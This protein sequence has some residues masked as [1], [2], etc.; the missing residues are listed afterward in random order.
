V[1]E[2]DYINESDGEGKGCARGR[3][4]DGR[5]I[6]LNVADGGWQPIAGATVRLCTTEAVKVAKHCHSVMCNISL[7]SSSIVTQVCK[8]FLVSLETCHVSHDVHVEKQ[9][10]CGWSGAP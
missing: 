8:P 1:K 6:K 5:G 7:I 10:R 4:L 3:A 2:R 9:N